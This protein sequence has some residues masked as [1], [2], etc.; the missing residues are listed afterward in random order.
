MAGRLFDGYYSV[1][2]FPDF[3]PLLHVKLKNLLLGAIGLSCC[4]AVNAETWPPLNIPKPLPLDWV[5]KQVLTRFPETHA[6]HRA[7]LAA[8]ERVPRGRDGDL[9]K[10]IAEYD[11]ELVRLQAYEHHLMLQW[12]ASHAF[13]DYALAEK[14][15]TLL[16]NHRRLVD[17]YLPAVKTRMARRPGARD[18]A[19]E[20]ARLHTELLKFQQQR[21]EAQLKLNTLM[22]HRLDANLPAAKLGAPSPLQPDRDALVKKALTNG[23]PMRMAGVEVKRSGAAME[24]ARA[25]RLSAPAMAGLSLLD[26]NPKAATHEAARAQDQRRATGARAVANAMALY[27]QARTKRD[28]LTINEQEILPRAARQQTTALAEYQ[29]GRL[30]IAELLDAYR[31]HYLAEV[32]ALQLRVDYEKALADLTRETGALPAYMEQKMSLKP[33]NVGKD[34]K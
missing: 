20:A 8:L 16:E 29:G 28:L 25:E 21:L 22:E 27:T 15:I 13:Y 26:S 3:K 7:Y 34:R 30:D 18:L 33:L 32:E 11:A 23:I 5:V 10:R 9:R 14:S 12:Q 19:I 31:A 17:A 6:K 1:S 2:W 4:L 24:L